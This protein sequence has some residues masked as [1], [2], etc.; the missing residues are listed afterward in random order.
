[1]ATK[2]FFRCLSITKVL[3]L[4]SCADLLSPCSGS[5][6]A[7]MLLL[8]LRGSG[9]HRFADEPPAQ[10]VSLLGSLHTF[11]TIFGWQCSRVIM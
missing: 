9:D 11:E 2:K 4:G 1:M 6:Q 5:P 7:E 8:D 3:S 10:E